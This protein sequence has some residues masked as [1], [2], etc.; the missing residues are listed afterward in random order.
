VDAG[1]PAIG[2]QD[3]PEAVFSPSRTFNGASLFGYIDGGAELYLE[4]GFSAAW[5]SEISLMRGKY[6]TEIYRMSGPEEAFGIFSVSKYRCRSMPRITSFTCMTN[7]Q[8]QVCAG[9]Y[10]ISIINGTGT[11]TDSVASVIIGEAIVNKIKETQAD[12]SA[13]LPGIGQEII[14]R[15]AILAK[16]KLG[17][18]NGAPDFEDYFREVTGYTAVILPGKE[19]DLLSLRFNTPDDLKKFITAHKLQSGKITQVPLKLI[20]GETVSKL[21]DNHLLITISK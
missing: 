7:F 11:K 19:S 5:V 17:I 13:F 3:I 14:K 4:Y 2:T 9:S 16:G 21:S 18:M 8:L 12:I 15:D 10:Y 20:N 1:F 6:K